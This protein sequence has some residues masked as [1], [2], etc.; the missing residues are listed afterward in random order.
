MNINLK[1]LLLGTSLSLIPNLTNA[2]CVATTDCASLGYT[3]TSCPD[4]KGIRC[5]FGNT[6]ACCSDTC[7]KSGFKYDCKGT[8][9]SS[10]AGQAC[11]NKYASCNCSS[12]YEWK[13]GRCEKNSRPACQVG[14]IY[15]SDNS[16]SNNIDKTKTPLGVVIY[17][18]TSGVGG[19]IM[20]VSYIEKNIAW[21]TGSPYKTGISDRNIDASCSNTEKLVKNGTRFSAANA[22]YNYS[23]QGTPPN[24][25]WCL[26]SYE[27]LNNLNNSKNFNN[28]NNTIEK[29]GGIKIGFGGSP[30]IYENIWSSSERSSSLAWTFDANT[31]GYFDMVSDDTKDKK[32]YI[33]DTVRPILEF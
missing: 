5:P 31:D 8:G 12:G 16:C 20:S 28:V 11:N 24:K 21:D 30:E 18:N 2:Q 4:G 22:A 14:W 9:Y 17:V 29:L 6:F 15:Y 32:A 25:K 19:Y 27:L 1:F 26:P 13:D 10:G 7:L 33:Y 23:P 3:E